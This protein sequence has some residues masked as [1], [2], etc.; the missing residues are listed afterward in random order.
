MS[1]NL[2]EFTYYVPTGNLGLSSRIQVLIYAK[3]T[4]TVVHQHGGGNSTRYT[5]IINTLIVQAQP[6]NT[7]H[8]NL[9]RMHAKHLPSKTDPEKYTA[10]RHPPL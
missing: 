10:K 6:G 4:Q 7:I 9:L 3:Y 8:L 5:V 2:A 1:I